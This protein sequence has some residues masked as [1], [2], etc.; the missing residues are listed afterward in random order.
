MNFRVLHKHDKCAATLHMSL[1][2]PEH[3][4]HPPGHAVHM[5]GMGDNSLLPVSHTKLNLLESASRMK[6]HGARAAPPLVLSCKKFPVFVSI[7]AGQPLPPYV[8]V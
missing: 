1:F 7:I 3:T 5:S 8:E 4:L 2:N 6:G